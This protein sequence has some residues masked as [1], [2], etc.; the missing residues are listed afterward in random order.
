MSNLAKLKKILSDRESTWHQEAKWRDENESWLA[1]SFDI[2]LRVLD[3]L[4][5]KKMTQKEL[6]E[7]MGVSPQFINKVVKGQENMSLE[8]IAK[9]SAALDIKLIEIVGSETR[10]GNT[11]SYEQAY[12]VSEQYRKE[13]FAQASAK[14]CVDLQQIQQYKKDL[15][16]EYKIPA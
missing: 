8:T 2:A 6:A 1:Q 16:L 3:T 7:R 14:G 5:A 15:E 9:L 10:P 11:Y 4:R 12:E 13:F